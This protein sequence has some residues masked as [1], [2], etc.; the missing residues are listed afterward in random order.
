MLS[1]VSRKT[2]IIVPDLPL[3]SRLIL[4]FPALLKYNPYYTY[5]NLIIN[6]LLK[7]EFK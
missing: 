6:K 2:I 4:R 3:K 7:F 1:E 5:S